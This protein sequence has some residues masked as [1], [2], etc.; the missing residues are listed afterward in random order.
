[1]Y[2]T[3]STVEQGYGFYIN[4][5]SEEGSKTQAIRSMSVLC[6]MLIPIQIG[7]KT[8]PHNK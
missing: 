5:L 2:S 3:C 8:S 1:M 7:H 4:L 6:K